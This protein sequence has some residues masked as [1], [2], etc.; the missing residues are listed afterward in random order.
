MVTV[1]LN[2][3]WQLR[4]STEE[5]C[6]MDEDNVQVRGLHLTI[7]SILHIDTPYY[8]VWYEDGVAR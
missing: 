6:V 1:T 7:G 8:E 3:G 4:C 2:N 5:L